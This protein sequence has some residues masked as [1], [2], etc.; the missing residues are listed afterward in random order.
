M[1]SDRFDYR[2]W[3]ARNGTAE[4][5]LAAAPSASHYLFTTL[6]VA[7]CSVTRLSSR[8]EYYPSVRRLAALRFPFRLRLPSSLFDHEALP[9]SL[10]TAP[11]IRTPEDSTLLTSALPSA[12]YGPVRL[13]SAVRHKA[14]GLRPSRCGQPLP[15]RGR[16]SGASGFRWPAI[17]I[18]AVLAAECPGAAF[19]A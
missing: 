2:L 13:P 11:L 1:M 12:H 15:S 7:D 10:D 3:P 4:S 8:L 6:L 17:A 16:S 19:A 5:S 14:Y 18:P 9:P